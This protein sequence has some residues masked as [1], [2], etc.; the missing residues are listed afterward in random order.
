M[1]SDQLRLQINI[2]TLA[3]LKVF[4]HVFPPPHLHFQ[5]ICTIYMWNYL[6]WQRLMAAAIPFTLS[7]VPNWEVSGFI[8]HKIFTRNFHIEE[9]TQRGRNQISQ[10]EVSRAGREDGTSN[11]VKF[12]SKNNKMSLFVLSSWR[13]VKESH[14]ESYNIVQ[15]TSGTRT[16]VHMSCL[17]AS[18]QSDLIVIF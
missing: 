11:H 7:F 5:F 9:A 10:W 18:F 12:P 8:S 13:V 6:W 4:V 16:G 14:P 3:E 17:R 2:W 1:Q 15:H